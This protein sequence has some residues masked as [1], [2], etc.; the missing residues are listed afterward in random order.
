MMCL[1]QEKMPSSS[2]NISH[3]ASD[4]QRAVSKLPLYVSLH[5]P[6]QLLLCLG[7]AQVCRAARPH[8]RRRHVRDDPPVLGG[9]LLLR[10][11]R[12]RGQLR[13]GR[14]GRGADAAARILRSCSS[15]TFTQLTI[16]ADMAS[17]LGVARAAAT[18]A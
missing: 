9:R 15:F 7:S 11:R 8:A 2:Q 3:D 18:A 14:G 4:R 13:E 12:R 17:R 1:A 16:V 5:H 6:A 10:L